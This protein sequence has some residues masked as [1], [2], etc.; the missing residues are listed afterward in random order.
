MTAS[1]YASVNEA[2]DDGL[3]LHTPEQIA[4]RLGGISLKT[5]GALIRNHGLAT[6]T[7]GYA[8]PSRKGGPGRRL[9]GMNDAQLDALLALRNRRDQHGDRT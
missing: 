9:W 5:L 3:T 6:T 8:E 1:E 2:C 4:E 7:L